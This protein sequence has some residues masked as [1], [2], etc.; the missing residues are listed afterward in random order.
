M[1]VVVRSGD[2]LIEYVIAKTGGVVGVELTHIPTGR[3]AACT[4]YQSKEKNGE[5]ALKLLAEAL[6]PQS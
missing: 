6:K 5:M 4:Q 3:K 2:L 1:S